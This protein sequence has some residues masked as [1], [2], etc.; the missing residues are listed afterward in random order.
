MAETKDRKQ[1]IEREKRRP[2]RW[3]MYF[4]LAFLVASALIIYKI[5]YIQYI[6]KPNPEFV[7]HFRPS[8]Q[9][10]VI[11]PERGTILDHNGRL[12]AIS[13]PLYDIYMDCCVQKEANEK[14]QKTGKEDEEKW[15]ENARLLSEGLAEILKNQGKDA[16]Y[17]WNRIRDGRANKRQYVGIVKGIDHGTL[18]ELQQLPL[19]NLPSHKGGLIVEKNERRLYPYGSL[20][21]RVIGYVRNNNDTSAIHIGIEGKY[22]H[23]L[24]GKKGLAWEK[25]TDKSRWIKDVDSLSISAE[26]GKDIRTTLDINIQDIADKALRTNMSKNS[27]IAA[28]CVVIMDV[29]TGAIKA[30]VNLQRDSLGR[31][32]E[33]FNMAAGRPAEP[34]SVFKTVTMTTLLEDRKVTLDMTI[35]TNHGRMLD[36]VGL[37]PDD[38]YIINYERNEKKDRISVLHGFQISSNYVFRRL[39]QDHYGDCPEEFTSRLHSYNLDANFDFELTERGSGKPSIPDRHEEGWSG[40]S[41][42]SSAIGYSVKV[43]PLQI[44]S[45]YNAIANDGKMMKPYIIEQIE[46]NGRAV[47][48]FEPVLLSSIC[49]KATADTLTRAL[50]QVTAEGTAKRLRTAKCTVAGK[51]GTARMHLSAA[52]QNGSGR[53][54]EDNKGRR[55]HQ[56]T[57]VGFFPAEQPKYSAIVVTYTDFLDMGVNVYGGETPAATFKDIVD[58]LWAYETE[59]SREIEADGKMPDMD[60]RNIVTDNTAGA[61][62]PD[63]TGMGLTDA[64][65]A[66][67]NSGYR[68][69]YTGCGHVAG[70]TPKGGSAA[71]KGETIKIVLR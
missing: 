45:F 44:V 22:N 51:T 25:R 61:P 10:E 36:M 57:F 20:A 67:E 52:E 50:M 1:R 29:E 27:H 3:L 32:Y 16:T 7:R 47:E 13:T 12:L 4:Y 30:M 63:V 49:S 60:A 17:Y 65:Y 5:I 53:P 69:S 41:L 56:G 68:C 18:L 6:W 21:R 54:Y 31:Y 24:H 37:V 15:M 39:V 48:I 34:G 8:K 33:A 58:E 46:E 14:N 66:I 62:V 64:I 55:K 38:P 9:K 43:T 28:G 42:V 35:P 26:D 59:W 70:Q 11:E 2:S 19:F 71:R 23:L 40:T